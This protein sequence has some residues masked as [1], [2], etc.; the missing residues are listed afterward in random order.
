VRE[1]GPAVTKELVLTCRPVDAT[2][3]KA[4]R[5][6]NTVVPL[7]ELDRTVTEMAAQLTQKPGFAL[8]TTKQQVNAV[9]EEIA[10]TGRSANDADTLAAAL[11]DAESVD[12]S[13]RYLEQR[14]RKR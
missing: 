2:E 8:R 13:R 4:L 7:A 1:L 12:A 9:M 10:G 3:A 14:A 11:T 5:L 6:V